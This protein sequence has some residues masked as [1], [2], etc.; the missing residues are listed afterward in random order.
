MASTTVRVV[1]VEGED[2]GGVTVDQD[3]FALAGHSNPSSASDQVIAAILGTREGAAEGGY[4]LLSTGV[5]WVDPVNAAALRD[6]LAARKVENVMLVSAFLPPPRWPTR[7]A[8]PPAI[9][10]PVCCSSSRRVRRWP[11]STRPTVRSATFAV[12]RWRTTTVRP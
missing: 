4:R 1:L 8:T 10:V 2:A 12:S 9:C 3:D 5:T 7:S 11:W 6:A